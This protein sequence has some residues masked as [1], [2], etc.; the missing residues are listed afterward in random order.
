MSPREASRVKRQRETMGLFVG[1]VLSLPPR[2]SLLFINCTSP[3]RNIQVAHLVRKSSLSANLRPLDWNT[4]LKFWH[5][6]STFA[7]TESF[8]RLVTMHYVCINRRARFILI[9]RRSRDISIYERT[10]WRSRLHN[11]QNAAI[12]RQLAK[13]R[14]ENGS[15]GSRIRPCFT[16]ICQT[17][18]LRVRCIV[19]FH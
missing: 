16:C 6:T 17:I 10:L 8:S 5:D 19:R 18:L 14:G 1:Q 3:T 4:R 9:S 7:A 11:E 12:A 15:L 13:A 2:W